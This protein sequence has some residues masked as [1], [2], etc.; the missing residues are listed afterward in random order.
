MP[1][2]SAQ[3]KDK[4]VIGLGVVITLVSLIGAFALGDYTIHVI[5]N[6]EGENN[7]VKSSGALTFDDYAAVG[8]AKGKDIEL[9]QAKLV[10][11]TVK[12][13]WVDEPN[14]DSRHT[15]QPD[16]FE[17]SVD[18]AFGSNKDQNDKGE[19]LLNFTAPDKKPWDSRDSTWNITVTCVQAGDQTPLVPD[20][21]GRRTIADGGN[22]Y[23]VDVTYEFLVK[24]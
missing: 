24:K 11:V 2:P 19:I 15:N 3:A 1:E 21:L 10:S 6:A 9:A 18:S 17:L 16:T 13:K 5:Q 12:L 7:T 20:P 22:A 4:G 23:T 14:A 8:G